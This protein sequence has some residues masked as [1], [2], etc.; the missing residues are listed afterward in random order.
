MP[1]SKLGADRSG[2]ENKRINKIKYT[3]Y[4]HNVVST[5]LKRP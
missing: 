3:Q 4:T 1:V 2:W 5:S